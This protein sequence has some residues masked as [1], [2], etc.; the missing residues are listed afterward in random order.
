[1]CNGCVALIYIFYI[2][3]VWLR[4]FPGLALIEKGPALTIYIILCICASLAR[5]KHDFWLYSHVT[6]H[7][8][9]G[10]IAFYIIHVYIYLYNFFICPVVDWRVHWGVV[11]REW[12]GGR[13][14]LRICNKRVTDP[15]VCAP[16]LNT[17]HP[18]NVS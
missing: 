16:G 15:I 18:I 1:M 3:C 17:F 6:F 8:R 5:E 12:S 10:Y 14:W 7:P 9:N 4:V 11:G 2:R 13:R